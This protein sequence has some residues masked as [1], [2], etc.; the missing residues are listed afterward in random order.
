MLNFLCRSRVQFRYQR[1]FED[2]NTAEEDAIQ[3]LLKT[4]PDNKDYKGVLLK[5]ITINAL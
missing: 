2:K 3:E 5:S 1:Q 4:F